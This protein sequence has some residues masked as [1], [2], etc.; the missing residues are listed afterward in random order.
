MSGI[1]MPSALCSIVPQPGDQRLLVN[2]S[3]GGEDSHTLMVYNQQTGR[4]MWHQ[5]LGNAKCV[6]TFAG[7][8]YFVFH[9]C[10]GK[11]RYEATPANAQNMDRPL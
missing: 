3:I 9:A 8:G 11:L 6:H 1:N 5:Y 7:G 4:Q 2:D 10:P